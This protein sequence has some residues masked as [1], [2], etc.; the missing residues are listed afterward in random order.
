MKVAL[1]FKSQAIELTMAKEY[2]IFINKWSMGRIEDC[3]EA[4]KQHF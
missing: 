3:V 2:F 1:S 4:M